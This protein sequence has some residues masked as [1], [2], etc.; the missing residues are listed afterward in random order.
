MNENIEQGKKEFRQKNYKEAL[1]YFKQVEKDDEDYEY[2]KIYRFFCLFELKCYRQALD[3]VNSLIST[4]PYSEILWHEKVRCHIFLKEKE[5]AHDALGELERVADGQNKKSLLNIARKYFLLN[6]YDKVTQYCD[7]AL[8][9]DEK[10]MPALYE[11]ALVASRVKD[12]EMIDEVS[13]DILNV[14][15]DD[16]LSVMPVFLLKL[17]SK[18]YDDCLDIV[19][20]SEVDDKTEEL[21]E[22]LKCALYNY[23]SDDLNAVIALTQDV[24]LPVGEALKLMFEFKNTGKDYGEI[25]GVNYFIL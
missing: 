7:M 2:A 9:L 25:H 17:F 13:K 14:S 5:K 18:K 11:K 10:Y 19:E 24:D 12:D 6:D 3:V 8:E 23:M 21:A 20:N 22:A 15:D 16:L 4:N 1:G